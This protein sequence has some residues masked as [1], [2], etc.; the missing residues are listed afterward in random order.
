MRAARFL[1]LALVGNTATA[2]LGAQEPVQVSGEV[3]C[4]ECVITL[5]TVVTIGGLDGPGLDAVSIFSDVAVDRRGRILVYAAEAEISAFDSTGRYLRTVGRR[6]EGPGEYGSISYIGVGPRYIH[7]FDRHRGR[8]ML[9]HDFEVIRTDRF[10]GQILSAA[11]SS[12]D[13]VMFVADVP[14]PVS[15]GHT[16]HVLRPSGELASHG[17]DGGV[18]PSELQPLAISSTVAAGKRGTVWKVP[19]EANRIVRW[20]LAPEP[21]VGRVFDR[22]VAE[23]DEGGDE[24]MPATLGSALVDE[25]GLWLVWH[26]ADP[27]W[28]GPPPSLESLKPSASVISQLRDGWLDLVDPATGRTLARYHQDNP[29]GKFAGNSGYLVGVNG[30]RKRHTFGH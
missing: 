23:F 14:T 1:A 7:V 5:D 8:T 3:T 28:D 21:K 15:V 13:V 16:F 6:G 19:T 9:D 26:T 2:P 4:A 25:R 20:D 29:L 30:H 22:R 24:F 12:D 11:V 27:D 17:Y 18:Y 10:P